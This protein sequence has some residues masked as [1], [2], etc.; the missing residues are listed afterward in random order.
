MKKFKHFRIHVTTSVNTRTPRK[1][2]FYDLKQTITTNRNT[3]YQ[4]KDTAA[5]ISKSILCQRTVAISSYSRE[6]LCR[7]QYH[8]GNFYLAKYYLLSCLGR[9]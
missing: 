7:R 9:K 3:I 2:I 8:V 1:S 4:M 6:N 5:E